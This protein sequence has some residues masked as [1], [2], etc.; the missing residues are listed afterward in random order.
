MF[1][2]LE[3]GPFLFWSRLVFTLAGIWLSAEFLL[4]LAESSNLSLQHFKQHAFWYVFTFLFGGRLFA[5]IADY[6]VYLREPLR[7]VMVN[8]GGFA[9]IGG[10]IGMGVVLAMVTRG[11]RSIF[12]QWLDALVPAAALGMV[13]A[14]LGSF[15]SGEAYGRPT[16]M[17][18]GVTYDAP[19][20]RY[21]IPV[22]PV[23]L[24]YALF[25]FALTFLLLVIRKKSKRVGTE[26]LVGIIVA[27]LMTFW[28]E[29]FRGDFS[30]PVFA[31][32]VDFILLGALFFS[33]G[34]FAAIELKLSNRAFL[35][36]EGALVLITCGYLISR[37]WLE[38]ETYEFRLSQ[39][40]CVL[41]VLA[42]VVYVVVERRKHPYF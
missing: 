42:S 29:N 4:R 14:W 26:T 25:Y 24:Y 22:H 12:L 15:F 10:I 31:T 11:H 9:F 20:V 1:Q 21:A 6:Q 40:L 36:Y 27:A 17:L 3:V 39:L 28:L 18:W 34:V 19:N 8:D 32:K 7:I 41:A 37:R 23:Q 30:I 35:L 38:L 5:I 33:L 13:F 2:V 16:D